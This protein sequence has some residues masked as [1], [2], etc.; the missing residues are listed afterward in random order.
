MRV[1]KGI[2]AFLLAIILIISASL[3]L[4]SYAVSEAIS[5]DAVEKAITETDAVGQLTD[6]II[7]HNTINLGGVYGET[8]QSVLK[9]DA[10]TAFFTEYTARCLQSQVYGEEME[11]IGSDDLNMAFSQGMDECLANGTI[12]MNEGERKMFDEAL[13]AAMPNLTKGVNYVLDQMDLDAFVDEDTAEQI[14]MARTATSD[15][16]R[17]GAAGIAII[18]CLLIVVLYWRSKIGLIWCGAIILIIAAFLYLLSM[19]IDQTL[20]ATGEGIVLS[21]QMLYVMVTYGAQAA[22]KVG[23]VIGGA[24]IIAFPVFRLVFRSR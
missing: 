3:A 1:I 22:M 17:Y 2:L 19:M 16:A 18:A 21:R 4:G 13:N 15:Q 9:S 5:E 23:A 24:M 8:M 6:N 11:E 12:S 7:Q 10:M 14:E 20:N